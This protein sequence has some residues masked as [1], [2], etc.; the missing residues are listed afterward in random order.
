MTRDLTLLLAGNNTIAQRKR[1]EANLE[2][3]WRILTWHPDTDGRADLLA[4]LP[5]ADALIGGDLLGGWPTGLKLGLYQIPYT[6][7]DWVSEE[8]LP[9][10]CRLC[11]TYEHETAIAEYI[12]LNLLEWQIDMAEI[13]RDFRARQWHVGWPT[14]DGHGELRGKTVGIVGYGHIGREVAM[15]C[16]SFGV[17]VIGVARSEKT[18][19]AELDWLGVCDGAGAADLHRLYAESDYIV[20]CCLL[21]EQTRGMVNSGGF[22]RMRDDAVLINVARGPV[23][24]EQALYDALSNNA[25]RGATIDVWYNYPESGKPHPQPSNFPLLELDNIR[26]SPHNSGS[27]RETSDRRWAS[28]IDNLNR[29]VRGDELRNV[30]FTG[31]GA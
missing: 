6:G 29:F 18:T 2:R 10:G 17:R 7:C 24:D 15:R 9:T 4:M 20:V 19:P 13:D 22:S 21:S 30:V 8:Q 28:V 5:Q 16:A 14:H 11:N 3:P 31:T 12:L 26:V 23:V 1:I 27:T 25:I